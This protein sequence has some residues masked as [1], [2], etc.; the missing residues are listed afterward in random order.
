MADFVFQEQASIVDSINVSQSVLS[1][2]KNS[3]ASVSFKCGYEG[4]ITNGSTAEYYDRDDNLILDG[5]IKEAKEITKDANSENRVYEITIYDYGYNLL[6]GNLNEIFRSL[7]PE[8]IIEDVV[9]ENGLTF[10]SLLPGSSGITITKKVYKDLDP[11]EAVNDMC[12][13]IGAVWRVSGT[14]FYLYRR[15]DSTCSEQIDGTTAG[16]WVLNSSG[17]ISDSDKQAKRVIIKGATIL[18]R[19]N[20]TLSGTGTEFY[21]SRTP[22]DVEISGLTQTT[23]SIDGDYVVDKE[24]KKITFNVSKTD[25]TVYYSYYSQLRIEIGD[26]EPVKVLVKSYIE[27]V[28]E[29]RKLG[30]KY[31]EAYQDGIQSATWLNV[32]IFNI[33]ITDFHVGDLIQVYNKLNTSRDGK[34]EIS[35]I[36]RKYP[37]K[38]EIQVGEDTLSIFD[39]QGESKERL[40][41]LEQK[42][43]NDDFL[44]FD[45]FSAGDIKVN[46]TSAITK[47]LIVENTGEILWAS[48][49]TLSNDA[50]LISDTGLDE[51]YALAYDDDGLPSGSYTDLTP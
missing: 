29:A 30:R 23:E 20:E 32:D 22:E 16:S 48:D 17:W 41:Q 38:I 46:L 18:Q 45:K 15:G 5:K 27:D 37:Q 28:T 36:T 1:Y 3:S 2:T 4:E 34:Y 47:L 40:K 10:N 21:L 51:D 50:D 9:E 26:G 14:D 12:D 8:E 25:P 49:T 11:M 24:D 13:L 42:D 43:Q 39:W 19:T 33:D 35:K 6:D 44:Q 7:S 31:I